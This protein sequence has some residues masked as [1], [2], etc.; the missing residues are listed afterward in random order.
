MF[1]IENNQVSFILD[2]TL[3]NNKGSFFLLALESLY[4]K[5]VLIVATEIKIQD[6]EFQKGIC[7][8]LNWKEKTAV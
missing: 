2:L 5:I 4:T 6:I 7:F 1:L 3:H 8:T